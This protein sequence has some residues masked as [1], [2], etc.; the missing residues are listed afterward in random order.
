LRAAQINT[1]IAAGEKITNLTIGDFDPK[2]Y[3]LPEAY[4]DEIIAAARRPLVISGR[5]AMSA[6]GVPP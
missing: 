2:V 1:R 4:L 6:G 5:G 3:P